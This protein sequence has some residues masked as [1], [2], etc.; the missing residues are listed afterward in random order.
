MKSTRLILVVCC[1]AGAA[2]ATLAQVGGFTVVVTDEEGDPLPAAT[3]TISHETGFIKT[4][5]ESTDAQ[6]T[7][8]FPCGFARTGRTESAIHQ[9]SDGKLFVFHR[10]LRS[11]LYAGRAF[12]HAGRTRRQSD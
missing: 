4:T 7:V 11:R 9:R 6:G 8:R 10:C 12:G 3:V 5:A 2:T 1:L